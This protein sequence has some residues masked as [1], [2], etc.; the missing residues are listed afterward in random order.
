MR[1]VTCHSEPQRRRRTSKILLPAGKGI[2]RDQINQREGPRVA[3][4]DKP[5]L[6]YAYEIFLAG[7]TGA[8]FVFVV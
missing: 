1:S 6:R 8:V 2:F 4:D 5:V 3:R 7:E